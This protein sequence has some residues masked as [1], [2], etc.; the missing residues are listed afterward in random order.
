MRESK[1]RIVNRKTGEWTV[2]FFEDGILCPAKEIDLKRS[3]VARQ[4]AGYGLVAGD[5]ELLLE[6][7]TEYKQA[8]ATYEVVQ[9][10]T[11]TPTENSQVAAEDKQMAHKL[12][13]QFTAIGII[14]GR[15][16]TKHGL[17]ISLE[18]NGDVDPKYY[19][20]HDEI[21]NARHR[22]IAH[23]DDDSYEGHKVFLVTN[24]RNPLQFTVVQQS[25]R[26]AFNGTAVIRQIIENLQALL[27]R[28]K[29]KIDSLQQR[30]EEEHKKLP[31][32]LMSESRKG[33]NT[34]LHRTRSARR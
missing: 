23:R 17:G 8:V 34:A 33:P 18:K 6:W 32:P 1:Y 5:I 26:V 22:Y 7:A 9:Q 2:D 11:T 10:G 12:F 24:P 20:I 21:M 27:S 19:H 28:V 3:H 14:Y 4:Y 25:N 13:A 30:L 16:F 15:L 31:L 29:G